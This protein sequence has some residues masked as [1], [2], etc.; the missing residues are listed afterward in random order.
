MNFLFPVDLWFLH[1]F[2]VDLADPILDQV[3]LMIT[4]LERQEWFRFFV[5][6][7][8]LIWA[9]Y[10]YRLSFFKVLLVLTLAVGLSDLLAYRVVK[11]LVNRPR[12]S[13]NAEISSWLRPVGDAHGSS[14]PSSHAAN[15]FAGAVVLAW[16]FRRRAYFFYTFAALVA[17]SR[18]A[19]GVHYPSDVLAGVILG[20]VVGFLTIT[21]L[22]NGNR[23]LWLKDSVMT[24]GVDSDSWRSRTRRPEGV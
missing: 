9:F 17:V 19:L 21:L 3:W 10:I 6:P 7:A 11:A 12:P 4:H 8:I 20:E 18:V 1:F 24:T 14:F 22:L 5:L 15:C 16:Y 2:N 23:R 13:E